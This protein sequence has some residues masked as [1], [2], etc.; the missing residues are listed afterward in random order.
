MS[1]GLDA[2]RAA[3]LAGL[4]AGL[5]ACGG[6]A[7]NGAEPPIGP[8]PAAVDGATLRL[9][10]DDYLGEVDD[11]RRLA[12]AHRRLAGECL[13][14]FGYDLPPDPNEAGIRVEFGNS[15]RYGI[16]DPVL[17]AAHGYA[18]GP[19][20]ARE[21]RRREVPPDA[22]ALDVLVGRGA[23]SVDGQA[24]PEG[25]CQGEAQRRLAGTTPPPEDP[26]LPQRLGMESW[27]RSAQDSRVRA[28]VA[29]WSDCMRERGL[30]YADP[31]GPPADPRF[32]GGPSPEEISAAAADLDCK[33][34][35]A[36]VPVWSMVETAYQERAIEQHAGEL[37]RLRT[38]QLSRF[39]TAQEV[40]SEPTPDGSAQ[41]E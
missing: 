35:S 38:W 20:P 1:R 40:L 33:A 17:A 32:R 30:D 22:V 16:T 34:R 2:M 15:R 39:R 18:P 37:A 14:R 12:D 4:A 19:E 10:L 29:A 31:L 28:A 5:L 24:V 13:S 9:P 25:G 3:G 23:R 41:R 26:Q 7:E 11:W 36:L 6:P 21:A 27:Q 8:V